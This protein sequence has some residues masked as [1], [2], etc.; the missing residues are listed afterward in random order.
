MTINFNDIVRLQNTIDGLERLVL[1]STSTQEELDPEDR[2]Q[3]E[4]VMRH[5]FAAS[6]ARAK[7]A[8][9]S[10]GRGKPSKSFS[11]SKQ[12]VPLA[13]SLQELST[14]L[15]GQ[16]DLEPRLRAVFEGSDDK[17]DAEVDK[18][19]EDVGKILFQSHNAQN[20]AKSKK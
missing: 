1:E 7:F 16:P 6:A 14:L 15:M 10:S 8:I 18:L 20:R 11:T 5:I 9:D 19:R 3:T 17:N 12:R 4:N 2:V 13:V